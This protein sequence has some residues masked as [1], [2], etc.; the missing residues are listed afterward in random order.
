MQERSVSHSGTAMSRFLSRKP[1]RALYC[2]CMCN[3]GHATA[4]QPPNRC[5]KWKKKKEKKEKKARFLSYFVASSSPFRCAVRDRS[6]TNL[7]GFVLALRPDDPV[8][9]LR[10]QYP[11]SS[12]QPSLTILLCC[13]WFSCYRSIVVCRPLPIMHYHILYAYRGEHSH[14]FMDQRR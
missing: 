9:M 7:I 4:T 2:Y 14:S 1:D 5:R 13:S 6:M 3:V 12:K 11:A 8:A 10:D